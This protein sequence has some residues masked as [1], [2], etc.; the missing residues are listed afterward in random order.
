MA[1]ELDDALLL[2]RANERDI[3]TLVLKT[4]GD[5]RGGARQRRGDG[6]AS[7][8]L[9]RARDDRRCCAAPC[10]GS[11]SPRAACS[12]SSTT[13]S[14]FA[15]SLFE[16][17]LAAD[18][19]YMLADGPPIALGALNFG[20]LE[21]INGRTRLAARFNDDAVERSPRDRATPPQ[22]SIRAW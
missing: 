11:T 14:C 3:G 7:R 15:G 21:M 6:R 2:L 8:P 22:R 16:L 18:R 17:A 4:R 12:R 10:S 1:R 5:I 13:G 19:S 9:V 20:G